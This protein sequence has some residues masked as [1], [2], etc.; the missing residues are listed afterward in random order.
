MNLAPSFNL[1][2]Q[3]FQNALQKDRCPTLYHERP[4]A[5][6]FCNRSRLV[7]KIVKIFG[8]RCGKV[9]TLD[10]FRYGFE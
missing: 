7:A 4:K 6:E 2:F 10:E 5:T 3:I 9:E 8:D 1:P